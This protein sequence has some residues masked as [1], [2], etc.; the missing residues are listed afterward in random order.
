MRLESSIYL[1]RRMIASKPG[2]SSACSTCRF[3]SLLR[4]RSLCS[5]RWR[6]S[7]YAFSRCTYVSSVVINSRKTN[8]AGCRFLKQNNDSVKRKFQWWKMS[9]DYWR[10]K[11]AMSFEMSFQRTQRLECSE[12]RVSRSYL[13]C[14]WRVVFFQRRIALRFQSGFHLFRFDIGLPLQGGFHW[15]RI[16]C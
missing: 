14:W 11:M 8:S 6:T 4:C 3:T 5:S 10:W 13:V 2:G 1:W 7:L 9:M 16:R 15:V 12:Q